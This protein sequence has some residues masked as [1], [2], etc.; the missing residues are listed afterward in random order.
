MHV[1]GRRRRWR[2]GLLLLLLL[3]S[4]IRTVG[5]HAHRRHH[6]H[7]AILRRVNASIGI[8]RWAPV[9]VGSSGIGCSSGICCSHLEGSCH[10]DR[11]HLLLGPRPTA[12][13]LLMLLVLLVLLM[14]LV[15]LL[16]LLLLMLLMLLVLLLLMLLVLLMLLMLLVLL[17]LLVLLMLLVLLRS[18]QTEHGRGRSGTRLQ[19]RRVVHAQNAARRPMWASVHAQ[20]VWH[21]GQKLGNLCL[22]I[23][24]LILLGATMVC[25]SGCIN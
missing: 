23:D 18:A 3:A 7:V 6:H 4:G 5:V 14:L 12:T 8:Q 16:M 15:L 22:E 1:R 2:Q 9:S 25:G 21:H 13:L 19:R 11:H 20:V 24:D 10:T 17:V